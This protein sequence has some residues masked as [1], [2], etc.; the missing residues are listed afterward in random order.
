MAFPPNE[1][2]ENRHERHATQRRA[3]H[4]NPEARRGRVDDGGVMPAARN[5]RADLLPLEGEVRR[6][7][8][9]RGPEG[10]GNGRRETGAGRRGGRG[11]AGETGGEKRC[12]EKIGVTAGSL[13]GG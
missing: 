1:E 3:D 13:G 7:G 6:D 12:L 10:G 9:R 2:E 11:G 4:R 8:Q 5:Q